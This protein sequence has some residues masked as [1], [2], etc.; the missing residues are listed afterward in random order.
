M[1]NCPGCR[2][3]MTDDASRPLM[4]MMT[5]MHSQSVSPRT[6]LCVTERRRGE[7]CVCVAATE[8]RGS[9]GER[10]GEVNNSQT[11]GY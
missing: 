8:N 2:G 5:L 11:L 9:A 3:M 4:M 7:V 10:E 1:E 6:D